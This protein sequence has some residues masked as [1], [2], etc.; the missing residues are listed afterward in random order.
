MLL[1]RAIT[2]LT[3]T[4]SVLC[5]KTPLPPQAATLEEDEKLFEDDPWIQPPVNMDYGYNVKLGKNV[6]VN[7][8]A[9]F[10]DTCTISLG[11]RTLVG[12][13]VSFFSATHPLD[14][15]IRNGTKGPEYGL[16]INIGEDCWIGGNVVILPGV[17]IGRGSVV[18]AGSVVTKS[19]PDFTIVAGNP[20]KFIRKVETAM[21]PAS[22]KDW[23]GW[24]DE[25]THGAEVPVAEVS[26]REA[27][28]PTTQNK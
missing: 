19:V 15:V 6:C 21:D 26:V 11:S 14:P 1:S 18:G 8:N 23:K 13:N 10:L 20:A 24:E 28:Q 9:T 2:A 22:G 12:P 25:N 4:C 5:D 7:F 17:R 27:E 16:E 3:L